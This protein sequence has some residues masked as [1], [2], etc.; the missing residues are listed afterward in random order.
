VNAE[1]SQN[2]GMWWMNL[3]SVTLVSVAV[4]AWGCSQGNG[5]AEHEH[6][7]HSDGTSKEIKAWLAQLSDEDRQLAEAQTFCVVNSDIEL[8]CVGV[9]Y[10]TTIEGRPVFL[11]CE[12]CK[13]AALKDPKA[14][15]AR[16]DGLLQKSSAKLQKNTQ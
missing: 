8:G 5:V 15:L 4:A 1:N 6:V 3:M 16:L 2:S 12:N 7:H 10:K 11:C 14:T 13:N 9:P